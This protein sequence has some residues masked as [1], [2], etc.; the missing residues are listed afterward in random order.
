MVQEPGP[1]RGAVVLWCSGAVVLWCSGAVVLWCCDAVMLWCSVQYSS[2][3]QPH[4]CTAY[5]C[6]S[7]HITIHHY[8]PLHFTAPHYTSPHSNVNP[9]TPTSRGALSKNFGGD[10]PLVNETV[11]KGTVYETTSSALG[12]NKSGSAPAMM[13]PSPGRVGSR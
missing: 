4:N 8:N 10:S 2:F 13:E 6:I 5:V 9:A 7:L 1:V 12:N 3:S 11:D